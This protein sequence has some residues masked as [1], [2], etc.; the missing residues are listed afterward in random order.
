MSDL[1]TYFVTCKQKIT[2]GHKRSPCAWSEELGQTLHIDVKALGSYLFPSVDELNRHLLPCGLIQGQF[3]KSKGTT[4]DVPYLH[5]E[6]REVR[7]LRHKVSK[8]PSTEMPIRW[9]RFVGRYYIS[10]LRIL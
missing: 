7:T 3:H 10:A 9:C 5:S 6:E 8:R 4:V 2:S 1:C